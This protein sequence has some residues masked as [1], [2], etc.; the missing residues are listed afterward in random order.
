MRKRINRPLLIPLQ[1]TT[2]K[3]A[4]TPS[5]HNHSPLTWPIFLSRKSVRWRGKRRYC[6]CFPSPCSNLLFVNAALTPEPLGVRGIP[7][8]S[9]R[10]TCSV[11][12]SCSQKICLLLYGGCSQKYGE[13]KGKVEACRG[14]MAPTNRSS[15][16]ESRWEIQQVSTQENK[17]QKY[18]TGWWAGV[19][20]QATW[21]GAAVSGS[22]EVRPS[23]SVERN[24]GGARTHRLVH[25]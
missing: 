24:K 6:C 5:L 25:A 7:P 23:A 21:W 12:E 2:L 13:P 16:G 22:A 10:N 14:G 3:L 11:W 4:N 20:S 15:H 19:L 9:D 1:S 18:G 17:N 8:A